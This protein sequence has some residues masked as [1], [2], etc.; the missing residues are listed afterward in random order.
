MCNYKEWNGVVME[1]MS[2]WTC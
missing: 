2:S 1:Q